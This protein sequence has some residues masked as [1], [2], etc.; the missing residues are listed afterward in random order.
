MLR[1]TPPFAPFL[2]KWTEFS[3][4]TESEADGRLRNL[5]QHLH[6]ITAPHVLPILDKINK[7][8]ASQTI[9]WELLKSSCV[10]GEL[11]Y[12]QWLRQ[13]QA[14]RITGTDTWWDDGR[15]YLKL[16][17]EYYDWDGQRCGFGRTDLTTVDFCGEIPLSKLKFVPFKFLKRPELIRE[18]LIGRGKVFEKM[19]GYQFKHYSG[20]KMVKLP[21]GCIKMGQV[22]VSKSMF[23]LQL[24]SL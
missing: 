23:V 15:Q 19:I 22:G 18:Q 24:T 20:T 16:S 13:P 4:A 1:F 3:T 9:D 6:D 17:V 8:R 14:Y 2:N 11:V 7:A 21:N 5:L 12:G 10:P